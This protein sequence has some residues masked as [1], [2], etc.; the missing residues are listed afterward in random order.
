MRIAL[1]IDVDTYDGTRRG[2]PVLVELLRRYD[3]RA[4]FFF[5]LGPDHTGRAIRRVFR[6]GF[7][8]KVSR[9]SVVANYGWKTLLYGT[10]WPGPDIGLKCADIMRET[11]R[12]GFETAIHCWDHT[13]WQDGVSKKGVEWVQR[14]LLKARLR[15]VQI[16]SESPC[17]IG[18]P[19]WQITPNALA[20]QDELGFSYCSDTRG[21]PSLLAFHGRQ[22]F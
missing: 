7:V 21:N 16:F 12:A 3:A 13:R 22:K 15:F 6:P 18:A 11:H 14:E 17:G 10:L 1:K 2:V 8:S 4:S 20:I 9:T 19:G 5:S